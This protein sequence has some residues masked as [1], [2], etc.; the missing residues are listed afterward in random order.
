MVSDRS[1]ILT[2]IRPIVSILLVL[3]WVSGRHS[4]DDEIFFPTHLCSYPMIDLEL[5]PRQT[6]AARRASQSSRAWRYKPRLKWVHSTKPA[7]GAGIKSTRLA[8][9]TR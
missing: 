4:N 8:H 7:T 5:P 1:S 3:L 9:V 6:L 2:F